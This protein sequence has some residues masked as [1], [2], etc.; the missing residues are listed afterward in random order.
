MTP[1]IK[2]E[3]QKCRSLIL[4][5][6]K[7]IIIDTFI[8]ISCIQY[9]FLLQLSYFYDI[10]CI[11][12]IQTT[13]IYVLHFKMK[14]TKSGSIWLFCD[15][16]V[17]KQPVCC[18]VGQFRFIGLPLYTSLFFLLLIRYISRTFLLRIICERAFS[19]SGCSDYRP[20]SANMNCHFRR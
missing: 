20:V 14:P 17:Y 5:A 1:K 13:S 16:F 9:H 7:L 3:R 11:F 18:F 15:A 2:S 4:S 19:F 8:T 12:F 6:L 10:I